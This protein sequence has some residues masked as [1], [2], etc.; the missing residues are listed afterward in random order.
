MCRCVCR[1][2]VRGI[3]YYDYIIIILGFCNG[4]TFVDLVKR[5]FYIAYSFEKGDD[6]SLINLVVSVYVKQH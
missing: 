6:P 2:G 3:Q 5:P 1:C 4:Y